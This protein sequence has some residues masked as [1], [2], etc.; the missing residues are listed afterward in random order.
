[1]SQKRLSALVNF[2]TSRGGELATGDN[3]QEGAKNEIPLGVRLMV[4]RRVTITKQL[5][6]ARK[7][8]EMFGGH[9]YEA[10]V[11]MENREIIEG[12]WASLRDIEEQATANS[13]TADDLYSESGRPAYLSNGAKAW[14]EDWGPSSQKPLGER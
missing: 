7:A 4:A 14:V 9:R 2:M 1:M 10:E 11:F 6:T 8:D 13:F 3:N 12:A 5:E